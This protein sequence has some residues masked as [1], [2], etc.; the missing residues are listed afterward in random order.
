[1]S[2]SKRL[3]DEYESYDTPTSAAT[4]FLLSLASNR[5]KVTFMP[6]L[7]LINSVL[8]SYVLATILVNSSLI[9]YVTCLTGNQRRHNVSVLSI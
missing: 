4:T 1:M 7:G 3:L 6:I 2:Y 8:A 5:T 9:A